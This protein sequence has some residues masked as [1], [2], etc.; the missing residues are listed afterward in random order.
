MSKS[1]GKKSRLAAKDPYVFN[2]KLVEKITIKTMLS[3]V[4]SKLLHPTFFVVVLFVNA[5]RD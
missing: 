5:C 4:L 3:A 2:I 1:E